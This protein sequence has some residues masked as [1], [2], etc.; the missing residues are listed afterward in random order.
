VIATLAFSYLLPSTRPLKKAL[1]EKK[2]KAAIFLFVFAGVVF[3]SEIALLLFAQL[4]CLLFSRRISLPLVIKTGVLSAVA[5][6]ALSVPI[7]SHFWQKPIWPEFAGF[8]YNAIQGKSKDWGISPIH[9]YFTSGI[10]RLLTNPIT[11]FLM[12]LA[13]I[14]PATRRHASDLILPQVLFIAVYSL[15]PHKEARFIIYSVPPLTVAASLSASYIWTRRSKSLIYLLG[16]TLLVGSIFASFAISGGMLL[17]SS[18]NYPGGAALAHLHQL[19]GHK[20][21]DTPP[22]TNET[23]NIHMDVLS[24]MTGVTRFQ[25]KPWRNIAPTDLPV[26]NDRPVQFVYDKTEDSDELLKPEFWAQFDYLLMEDPGK[27]IGAWEVISTVSAYSGIEILKPG[28]GSSFSENLE[29][30]YAANNI[31]TSNNEAP[32]AQ[33]VKDAVEEKA[34]EGIDE[35]F[36]KRD[37]KED[38][39]SMKARLLLK[40]LGAF[41]SYGLVRDAVRQVTGGWWV[42]PRMEPRIRIL[43]RIKNPLDL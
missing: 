15:Q 4:L 12:P 20:H 5:S 34:V 14:L 9:Y 31:T 7:D 29:R 17:I 8:Y 41:G 23:I 42:G 21:W 13:S 1:I 33:D 2:Q 36:K 10:P 26:I 39:E 40:E 35:E 24:C 22:S 6:L 32:S 37:E 19:L 11:L 30:V 25:E 28:D 43:R 16:S 27:A 3:R 38:V 18:L